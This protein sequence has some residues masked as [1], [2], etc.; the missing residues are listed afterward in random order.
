MDLVSCPFMYF[1]VYGFHRVDR[2]QR[3]EEYGLTA[4]PGLELR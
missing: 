2:A 1:G 4:F 3:R